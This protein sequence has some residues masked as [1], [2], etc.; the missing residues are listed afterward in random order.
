MTQETRV[1]RSP[2]GAELSAAGAHFRVWAPDRRRV[3]VVI[4]DGLQIEL[5]PE[6]GGYFAGTAAEAKVGDRYG[7]S[8]DGGP[9]LPDPA[10]RFQP[11]GP[12]GLSEIVD[13]DGFV[14]SDAEWKGIR[15]YE[16]ILYEM[17][18]GAFTA[19]GDWD[20]ATE[21]LPHLVELGVTVIELMP[22]AE[23]AGQF[24]WGY[25]GVDLFAPTHLYGRPDAMRR[26][27]NS[28]HELGLA[29]I[30]DVVYNHFGPDGCYV[31]E[32]SESY[33]SERHN[34]DWGRGINFDGKSSG[35][36]REFFLANAAYW[37]TEFHL[38]GLRFDATQS[39]I[40]ESEEPILTALGR[41]ARQAGGSR[42]IYLVAENE[43]QET[44]IARPI[45]EGG[46][47]LDALWNDDFHHTAVVALTGRS[48]A[49]YT[50][51]KG[52]PQEFISAAKYGYLYQGQRYDWQKKRRGKPSFGV[53]YCSFI[54]Y[55]ENH[56]QTANSAKGLRLHQMTSPGLHRAVTACL[57]LAPQT[58]MLFQGQ[59]YSS[60]KPFLYFADQKTELANLVRN[61]RTEFLAQFPRIKE[62][63]LQ[64]ELADPGVPDTFERCKL[65]WA[66]KERHSSALALHK[67][68]IA[69]RR[70]D[71]VLNSQ[72]GVDGAVLSNDC[73]LLR[74]FAEDR[75]DRL[76]IVNLGRDLR[77][78][79]APEPLLA[80]PEGRRWE[81]LLSTEDPK[82]GGFGEIPLEGSFNWRIPAQAAVL[83][84]SVPRRRE[85][86]EDDED[87]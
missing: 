36:V 64:D 44:K 29:V 41:A 53:L 80:P 65:D 46:N 75:L 7:F 49:Y 17:H 24:G 2:V 11:D 58:P 19:K 66:E 43:P 56:D 6:A 33:F 8:L 25:D 77:V 13:P 9:P 72:A 4:E 1:R 14:W 63:R 78:S 84:T 73:L 39:I 54:N 35:P 71:P 48:E 79:P 50:D 40:D 52:S 32:F 31:Q 69:L 5:M 76:L 68:L 59:E 30:L 70:N 15:A 61:G 23:F 86:E 3:T 87:T 12:H 38:D 22:V 81:P 51:Y 37:I 57:L 83:M 28:A 62:S 67:D 26:F 74:Y 10:S 27:V 20:A 21:R 85:G 42:S 82:Y 45:E 55:L 34:T 16:A 18:V 47:G 60:T